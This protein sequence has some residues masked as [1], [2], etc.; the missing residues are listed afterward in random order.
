MP[1]TKVSFSVIQVANNVTST[2]VGNTTSIPSF[3]FD[4]NGV[5]TSASNT[6]ISGA[7]ITANTIANSA[8]QTGSI[9]NYSRA[10]GLLGMR[11]R[12]IN[13]AMVIDQ[14]NAGASVTPTT[15][16]FAFPV[17][18][19]RIQVTQNSKL[20]AQQNA[21]SVT[22]PVGFTNYLGITSSSAYS[23]VAGD[24][25]SV[26]QNIEGFNTADLMW[27]TANAKTVTLSFQVY[28]SLTGTFGGA[29]YNNAG[30]RS[31]PFSYSIP[32]AN[33][34]TTINI[35][36]AGDT[37]GTWLT[38]NSTGITVN[39]SVGAGSTY[40]G[41]AGAWAG[42]LYTSTTGATSVVGTNGATFY[43]TGVQLEVGSSAT[44]F[45]YRSYGTELN[46]CQ[47]YYEK[48]YDPDT[49][50]SQAYAYFVPTGS[51]IVNGQI[52][53][54]IKYS[55]SKRARPTVTVYP[56]TTP[57]NTMRVS[58]A[59]NNADFGASS[60]NVYIGRVNQVALYNASGGTLTISSPDYGITFGW[61]ADAEL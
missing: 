32:V 21:G 8:F 58:N 49:A 54:T 10:A 29:L 37:T 18:R 26:G 15:S 55:V 59:N 48:A 45:E 12:I 30:N 20:T 23:V 50:P 19:M 13:G 28:S 44:G 56:F 46:L 52:H 4:Q 7:G 11:N 61:T 41:T 25:F 31:Y 42:T 6:A 22:P 14:R 39:F 43:I 27:G 16:A 9:E 34:W 2:T 47:R 35:T 3:T 33:T 57:T 5:I 17:D 53:S 36:I 51:S 40:S 60:G 38:N 1:L 24:I